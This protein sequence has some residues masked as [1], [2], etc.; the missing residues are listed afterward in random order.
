MGSKQKTREGCT[1]FEDET[2][3]DID[4]DR[5]GEI[6]K[7]AE[8]VQND[9]SSNSTNE[10]VE[11]DTEN[12]NDILNIISSETPDYVDFSSK[13]QIIDIRFDFEFKKLLSN[14]SISRIDDL[15]KTPKYMKVKLKAENEVWEEKFR[16]KKD[17]ERQKTRKFID[18]YGNGRLDNL[19]GSEVKIKPDYINKDAKYEVI[20]PSQKFTSIVKSKYQEFR[21]DILK[22]PKNKGD[23]YTKYIVVNTIQLALTLTVITSLSSII[24]YM[25]FS[26]NNPVLPIYG[27]ALGMIILLL[28]ALIVSIVALFISVAVSGHFK[29]E[30]SLFGSFEYIAFN[31]AV[32]VKENIVSKSRSLNQYLGEL[33]S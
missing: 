4:E 25:V 23:T 5:L 19:I 27:T 9:L 17:E 30:E 31:I 29:E 21:S 7:A 13:A 3:Q 14:S 12:K 6:V 15:T 32:N 24:F 26:F 22:R 33:L 1:I 18:A 16:F 20:T 8:I 2:N 10:T 28:L 11:E